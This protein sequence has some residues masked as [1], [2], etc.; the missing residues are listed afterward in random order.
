MI[1]YPSLRKRRFPLPGSLVDELRSL[2]K[3][4]FAPQKLPLALKRIWSGRGIFIAPFSFDD[5]FHEEFK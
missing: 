4:R 3:V 2:A 1:R 5:L